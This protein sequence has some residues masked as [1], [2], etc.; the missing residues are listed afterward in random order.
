MLDKSFTK[1]WL[2]RVQPFTD[3]PPEKLAAERE[4][5][6]LQQEYNRNYTEFL[7]EAVFPAVDELVKLLTQ[8]R[9]IHRVSA[10]GVTSW[11]CGSIWPGGGASWS[12]CRATRTA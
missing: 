5:I 1:W 2:A 12:S 7:Q 6:E 4:A 11:Q 3:V 10:R 9:V 8:R